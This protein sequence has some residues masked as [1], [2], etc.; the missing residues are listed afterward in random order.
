MVFYGWKAQDAKKNFWI[1]WI[2]Q[3]YYLIIFKTFLMH[4]RLVVF[5]MIS[6]SII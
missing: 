3:M 2:I 1:L 4:S 6:D 5:N